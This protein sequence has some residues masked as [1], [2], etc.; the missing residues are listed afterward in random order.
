[1]HGEVKADFNVC[2][3]RLNIYHVGT[4][5][6]LVTVSRCLS[7]PLLITAYRCLWLSLPLPLLKTAYRCLCSTQLIDACAQH[8]LLLPVVITATAHT[9]SAHHCH[10]PQWQCSPL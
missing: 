7:L 3:V 4:A 8:S 5:V 9:A 6:S 2:E 1:M 10:S